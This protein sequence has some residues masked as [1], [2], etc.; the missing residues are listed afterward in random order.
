MALQSFVAGV[1]TISILS[2][3]PS[4]VLPSCASLTFTA[5]GAASVDSVHNSI[6]GQLATGVNYQVAVG[7]VGN[8]Y[9][10]GGWSVSPTTASSG[11]ITLTN[12]PQ[13]C[14]NVTIPNVSWP[15]NFQSAGWVAVFLAQGAGGFALAACAPIDAVNDMVIPI[16]VAPL[17]QALTFPI[18]ILNSATTEST[19]ALGDRKPRGYVSTTFTPTAED[20]TQTDQV[21]GSVT[22]TPNTS[23]DFTI[24]S[25]RSFQLAFKAMKNDVKT[26][27]QAGAG[28]Y[29]KVTQNGHSYYLSQRATNTASAVAKGNQPL[30]IALPPDPA[31]GG[32]GATMLC[33]SML[34][35][36]QGELALAWSKKN[37]T[38]VP[39]VYQTV[40]NDF[41]TQSIDTVWTYLRV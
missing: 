33:I 6:H 21:S 28:D 18:T 35:Q 22:F 16:N 36:N 40:P 34:L 23:A 5:S 24:A 29:A 41:L 4:I 15:A 9:T 20:I 30:L 17:A 37:Q 11:V 19:G 13:D 7:L 2:P 26:L 1:S 14:I 39:F 3:T 12:A 25:V 32:L 10:T 27:I 8:D 31:T 38:L